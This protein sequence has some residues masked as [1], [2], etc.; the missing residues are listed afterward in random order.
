MKGLRSAALV[1]ALMAP[2]NASS[3]R[4][5][6]AFCPNGS[7]GPGAHDFLVAGSPV[8]MTTADFDGDGILDVVVVNN[9]SDGFRQNGIALLRG[10]RGGN[11]ETPTYPAPLFAA[12]SV[13]AADLNGDGKMD[14]VLA[15]PSAIAVLLGHGDGTFAPIQE[16][17]AGTSPP[18]F[19]I[20]DVN[21]DGWPDL[22]TLSGGA[23]FALRMNAGDGSFGPSILVGQGQSGA[24]VLLADFNRDSKLD[25]YVASFGSAELFLGNGDG[26][27]ASSPTSV[28]NGILAAD[29]NRDGKLDLVSFGSIAY[30]RGDGTFDAPQS[31]PS[32][33]VYYASSLA[34]ADFNGDGWPDLV[35]TGYPNTVAMILSDGAGGFLAPQLYV[36][37]PSPGAILAADF[38]RDGIP[39]AAV[40][41]F[42]SNTMTLF[43]GRPDGSLEA[44]PSL[45]VSASALAKADFNGDGKSDLVTGGAGVSIWLGDGSGGFQSSYANTAPADIRAVA[46]ANLRGNGKMDVVAVSA[47]GFFPTSGKLWVFLGDGAGGASALPM[48]DLDFPPNDLWAGDLDGDGLPDLV[49]SGI[50]KIRILHGLGNGTFSN[51]AVLGSG[52]VF[53]SLVVQ[54]LS[55]DGK[56]DIAAAQYNNSR[57]TVFPGNGNGTFG[58]PAD[59]L[60]GANPFSLVA[61]DFNEDGKTDLLAANGYSNYSLSL[62]RGRGDGT[63]EP[64]FSFPGPPFLSV[65]M[66][67]AD[68]TG[69]GKPDIALG[70]A[71]SADLLMMT[72]KGDG[73]FRA[74]ARFS[75]AGAVG[76][77]L[78]GD[79]NGD[80][81]L[82]LAIANGGGV[83]I[84]LNTNC[85][86]RRLGVTTQPGTC[87]APSALFAPQPVIGLFDDG[88]NLLACGSG[89]VSASLV[90]GDGTPGAVLRGQTSVSV[91]A[92]EA[93]FSDLSIDRSGAGYVL[94]FD[95]AQARRTRAWQIMV[96][97]ALPILIEGPSAICASGVYQAT[98][99]FD[100]YVW[101]VDDVFV[102]TGS[103]IAVNGVEI[104]RGAHTIAVLATRSGCSSAVS[105][106][107][108]VNL[109]SVTIA[110]P[111]AVCPYST[112]VVASVPD[113]GPGASYVW[114]LINA[115][116]AAGAGTPSITFRAG[117]SGIVSISV[118]VTTAQGC[119]GM[120]TG[121]VSIDR[122]LSCAALAG[123]FT[124]SP[125][126]VLDTRNPHGPLGGPPLSSGSVRTFAIANQCG[127]PAD[128]TSVSV[129][130]TIA[131]P[132]A[133]GFLTFWP[134][135][136]SPP[137]VSMINFR[138]GQT[139]ANNAILSLG[140]AGD[141][142]VSCA[143]SGTVDFILDVNGYFR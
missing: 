4:A 28:P 79:W 50:G 121:A 59:Y 16:Y 2:A 84:L 20:G 7:F 53:G 128:A 70:D 40:V 45:S 27:F 66:A 119:A 114:S 29:F 141:F 89:S 17:S 6:C 109:P 90:A 42:D 138:A 73:T 83:F 87:T 32:A 52:S 120:S 122:T 112:G 103:A 140:A 99:G 58:T 76:R 57:V 113:A 136:T 124:L 48:Q 71:G 23:K 35:E 5:Q 85:S 126:R 14:L 8:A 123:F 65:S 94:Q 69:D 92:G 80:G 127:V 38:D 106:P 19:A 60:L 44:T 132:T 88:D 98:P 1:V 63:F 36:S 108:T 93:A 39:D 117:P 82:D 62:L 143:G 142:A 21:G 134:N 46:A 49:I 33:T 116:I 75:T 47:A 55:G 104:G 137:L 105:R 131:N 56:L 26:M 133:Q 81:K 96:G 111:P 68:F 30:G 110:A 135:G 97:A 22:V 115:V 107:I 101:S 139:R 100:T 102:G 74:S 129:N 78:T 67:S 54:D 24:G 13:R 91:I 118:T 125:C 15:E 11:F 64:S 31:I 18:I 41:N 61:G 77:I 95:H 25:V 51:G 130:V 86:A 72:G 37:G 34:D 10:T 43:R 9:G 3:L 12:G